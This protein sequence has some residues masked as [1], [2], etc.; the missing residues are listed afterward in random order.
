MRKVNLTDEQQVRQ[1]GLIVNRMLLQE[2]Q[3]CSVLIDDTAVNWGKKKNQ[4]ERVLHVCF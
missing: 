4:F 3:W 2:D 1:Y